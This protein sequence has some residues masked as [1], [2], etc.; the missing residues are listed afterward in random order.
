M[1]L[2][3]FTDAKIRDKSHIRKSKTILSHRKFPKITP[4]RKKTPKS[5]YF[6]ARKYCTSHNFDYFCRKDKIIYIRHKTT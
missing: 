2:E 4:T 6:K 1:L 5:T 3:L